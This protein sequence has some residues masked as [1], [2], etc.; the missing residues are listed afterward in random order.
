[1]LEL[2]HFEVRRLDKLSVGDLP[3]CAATTREGVLLMLSGCMGEK[4]MA[5]DPKTTFSTAMFEFC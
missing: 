1:M 2:R 4:I 5:K 3:G